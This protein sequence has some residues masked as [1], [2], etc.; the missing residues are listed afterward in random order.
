MDLTSSPGHLNHQFV[1][2]DAATLRAGTEMTPND[3]NGPMNELVNIILAGNLIPN[4]NNYS[5]VLAALHN[6]FLGLGGGDMTGPITQ[7]FSG[8]YWQGT[9]VGGAFVRK[10][11]DVT[12]AATVGGIEDSTVYNCAV[13]PV[14][15]IWAGRDTA[16]ICWL[17]KWSDVGGRKEYWFAPTA[18]AGVVP[19]W[20]L[21]F[22][23]DLATG[24]II[25]KS[26]TLQKFNSGAGTYTLPAGCVA[27]KVRA[28]GGGGGGGGGV[29]ASNYPAGGGGQGG[30]GELL[31]VNPAATY[32]YSVGSGGV[33]GADTAPNGVNG[34]GGGTTTFGTLSCAGGAGGYCAGGGAG[35]GAGGAVSGATVSMNG[36]CGQS[37][38]YGGSLNVVAGGQGGGQGGGNSGTPGSSSL[39][40]LNGGG[41]AGASVAAGTLFI[42][43]NG[44][45]GYIV[46]EEYYV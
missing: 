11:A 32:P 1:A 23:F 17:E 42:G 38:S 16:D 7:K 8:L 41:G 6:I 39:A 29:G 24:A 18:A 35:G 4:A 28:I 36:Q 27:I 34:F 25:G 9:P 20:A 3:M 15:G 45:A 21:M 43:S 37:V 26:R 33:K 46:V 14:T 12:N 13:D 10:Y 40:G 30:Y 22:C 19:V 44:G 5:Q 2:E 31:I